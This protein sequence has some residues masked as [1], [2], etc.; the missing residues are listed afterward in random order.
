VPAD[1]AGFAAMPD[2]IDFRVHDGVA[3]I[4]M[5]DGKVN[6]LSPA[7]QAELGGALDRAEDAVVVITGRPGVLSAGFDLRCPPDAWPAMVQGGARLAERLLAH[8][9]PVV[10]AVPGSAVAMGALLLLACD[11]RI[12]A[13]GDFKLGLNEVAIGLTLPWFGVELARHRLTPPAFDRCTVTGEL[14]G[15]EAARE[16]GFLDGVVAPE[17]L[18]EAASEAAHGLAR[19]DRAAHT[20]T[21]RRVRAGALAAVRQAIERF[22][23]PPGEW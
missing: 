20:A 21:K 22:S 5:D 9:A 13:A 19:I 3:T 11:L 12:G 17:A 14:V 7:M 1:A 10:A 16:A 6:A 15:P 8:P 23:G 4:T 18:A 2:R